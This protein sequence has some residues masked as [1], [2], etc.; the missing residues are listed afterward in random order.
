MVK[1]ERIVNEFLELAKISSPSL[2]EGMIAGVVKEKLHALGLKAEMDDTGKMIGG[3]AGNLI[4]TLE[5]FPQPGEPGASTALLLSAHLDTVAPGENVRPVLEHDI[6][7]SSGDTILGADAKAGIAAILEALRVITEQNVPHPG[8]VIVFSVAE[9]MGLLGASCLDKAMLK[10][11][12]GIVLDSAGPV[13]GMVTRGP[14]HSTVRAAIKGKA[15]HA[16]IEPEQGV[17]AIQIAAE[18]VRRMKLG[19]VDRE[20]TANIGTINGGR[21]TN[22]VPEEVIIEGEARSLSPEKLDEQIKSMKEA[23]VGAAREYGGSAEVEARLSY[24]HIDL[25]EEAPPVELIKRAG[26]KMGLKM[27]A[28]SSGGGSDANIFNSMGIPTVNLTT[29]MEKV[30]TNGEFIRIEELLKLARLVVEIVKQAG[31][32]GS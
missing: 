7:R 31:A 18:A 6:I 11:D 27:K 4:A 23:V 1:R 10:A 19:R 16:G 24:P 28:I 5:P 25:A 9:E 30:H 29:G 12:W 15:A 26:E 14:A 20:T 2:R 8:L 3:E 22:I 32:G 13:G 17:S 21:A